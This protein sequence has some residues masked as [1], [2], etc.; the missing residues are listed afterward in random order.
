VIKHAFARGD[1]VSVGDNRVRQP[2]RI[3]ESEVERN[4]GD[5]R[6]KGD[7]GGWVNSDDGGS[8]LVVMM[9]ENLI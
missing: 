1:G 3:A 5:E 7:A 9:A 8:G 6:D 4:A 2:A